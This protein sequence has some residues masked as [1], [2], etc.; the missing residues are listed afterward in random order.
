MD[1]LSNF[2]LLTGTH[3]NSRLFFIIRS[4]VLSNCG[5]RCPGTFIR[6]A[7]ISRI[8]KLHDSKFWYDPRKLKGTDK[9]KIRL[10]IITP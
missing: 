5:S 3:K 6:I 8:A 10:Y 9:T 1:L 4:S 7:K 2:Y